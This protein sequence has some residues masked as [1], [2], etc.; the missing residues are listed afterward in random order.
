MGLMCRYVFLCMYVYVHIYVHVYVLYYVQ[1]TS[2]V[3]EW[4]MGEGMQRQV[5]LLAQGNLC[6]LTPL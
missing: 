2:V 6:D 5:V 4:L 1:V 3:Y